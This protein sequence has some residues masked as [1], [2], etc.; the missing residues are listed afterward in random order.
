M[1]PIIN[2][3]KMIL[4]LMKVDEVKIQVHAKEI[5]ERTVKD[6]GESGVVYIPREFVGK[7]VFVIIR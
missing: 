6:S 2:T 1:K 7:E 5:L 4:P 3:R